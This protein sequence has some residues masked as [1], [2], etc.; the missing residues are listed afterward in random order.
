MFSS[1]TL[2]AYLPT[3]WVIYRH[4]DSTQHSLVTWLTWMGANMTMAAW[5]YEK[6]GQRFS[7]AVA[8]SVGNAAMC[9]ATSAML[10]VFG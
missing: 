10:M 1:L 5:L 4:A 6:N 7:R 2:A 9:L 8:V 3:I